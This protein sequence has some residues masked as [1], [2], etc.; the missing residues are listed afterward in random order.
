MTT[1]L[2]T[3]NRTGLNPGH[4]FEALMSRLDEITDL[5]KANGE[6]AYEI[7]SIVAKTGNDVE[8]H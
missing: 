5:L 8:L 2:Q 3:P 7:G 1:T 4:E 6:T